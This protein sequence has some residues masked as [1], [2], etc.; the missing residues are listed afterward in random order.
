[1][2]TRRTKVSGHTCRSDV[3]WGDSKLVFRQYTTKGDAVEVT[4]GV[5]N[6][7]EWQRIQAELNRIKEYWKAR[8]ADLASS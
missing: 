8:V 4:V 2:R 7:H 3:M 5:T 1:M 6:P